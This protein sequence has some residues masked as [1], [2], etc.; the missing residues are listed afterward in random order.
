MKALR[1]ALSLVGLLA[2]LPA[3][4]ASK[5][6]I[7]SDSLLAHADQLE[8]KRGVQWGGISKWRFGDYAVVSSKRG[9]TRTS[10]DTNFFKTK[11]ERR[12]GSTFSFVMSN[13]ASDSAFVKAAHD[14]M[15]RTNPGLDLG[16]GRTMGGDGGLVQEADLFTASIALNRDTTEAWALSIGK[17]DVSDRHGDSQGGTLAATLTRGE[18]HIVLTPVYSRKLEK[19]P[20]F[21]SM[22]KMAFVVPAMGYEFIEDSLSLCALEYF[23]SGLAGPAKNT[24]WMRRDADARMQLVLAAAM[25][26]VLELECKALEAPAEPE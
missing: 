17:T 2:A 8:V 23:S 10:A 1:S 13:K 21:G 24:I 5:H 7:I 16:K 15:A 4:A 26:A 9:W 22:L 12:S 19:R 20:S 6:I 18:R 3:S 14:L 25:T 11:T